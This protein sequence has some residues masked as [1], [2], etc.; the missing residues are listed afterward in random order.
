MKKIIIS[1]ILTATILI[2][3]NNVPKDIL[4]IPEIDLTNNMYSNKMNSLTNE[5]MYIEMGKSTYQLSLVIYLKLHSPEVLDI[6]RSHRLRSR[7]GQEQLRLHAEHGD[8]DRH[9][10]HQLYPN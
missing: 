9:R 1:L 5:D 10:F 7:E 6:D 8:I 3:C 2:G 4:S